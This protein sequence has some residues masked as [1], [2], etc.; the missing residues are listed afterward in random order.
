MRFVP[1]HDKTPVARSAEADRHMAADLTKAVLFALHRLQDGLPWG[2]HYHNL[3]HTR[4]VVVP[5]AARLG[6]QEAVATADLLLLLTA[7][8]FHD[9]G[10]TRTRAGHE[11][12]GAALAGEVL[13]GFGYSPDQVVRV[14]GLILAT[15]MPQSPRDLLEMILADADLD[16]LGRPDFLEWSDRLRLELSEVGETYSDRDWYHRQRDFLRGHTYHTPVRGPRAIRASRRI[17]NAC[18]RD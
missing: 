9:I 3:Q 14:G 1:C 12:S 10:F 8:W 2:L 13:P 7:A 15:E 11:V 6:R 17:S 5:A 18:P 4:D 16:G